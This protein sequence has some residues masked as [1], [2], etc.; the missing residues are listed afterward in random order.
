MLRVMSYN[1]SGLRG[2]GR[3]LAEVVGALEPDV[4]ILQE[5]PRRLRWRTRN[6]QLAH[7]V[8][9]V[10]AT[11]GALSLGNVIMTSLR[12]RP[13]R[14][15]ELRYPLT[16]GRH[17]RGAVFARCTAAGAGFVLVGSH[18]AADPAERPGQAELLKKALNGD[19]SASAP[20]DGTPD[21]MTTGDLDAPV[22]FAGDLNE[23]AG[24]SAWRMLADGLVD[25]AGPEG[26]AGPDG[27]AG[28]G[29]E[30]IFVDPRIA[31]TGYRVID[32]PAA[33][34]VSGHRPVVADLTLPG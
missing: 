11:G 24:G 15:W 4:L 5:A 12:V 1:V 2:D 9:L 31:V 19:N 18:L 16:P 32:S 20:Q 21:R 29:P 26:P 10:Y 23:T 3:A 8:G 27:T 17:M 22:I 30:A 6:A 14:T 33:R 28:R 13:T 34:R 7:A 25:T